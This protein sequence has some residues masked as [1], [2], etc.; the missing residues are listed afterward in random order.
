MPTRE[1]KPFPQYWQLS[2]SNVKDATL[3]YSA[4]SFRGRKPPRYKKQ[5]TKC[6]RGRVF[7][8]TVEAAQAVERRDCKFDRYEE[9]TQA[10][11]KKA[12]PT[13]TFPAMVSYRRGHCVAAAAGLFDQH[14]Q[15]WSGD[16][17]VL[18]ASYALRDGS[19]GCAKITPS[20]LYT[21][22]SRSRRHRKHHCGT[23]CTTVM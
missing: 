22:P 13:P 20:L 8:N 7:R 14:I 12:P 11:L 17:L 3:Q 10:Q 6:N 16:A 18:C 23:P 2:R 15:W 1:S 19:V 5:F 4:R 9:N 21:Y